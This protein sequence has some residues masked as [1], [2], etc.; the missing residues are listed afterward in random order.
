MFL[1]KRIEYLIRICYNRGMKPC[2]S[3]NKIKP[4]EEFYLQK[5]M[6]DSHLN[7]CKECCKLQ[8]KYRA[9]NNIHKAERGLKAEKECFICHQVK[10]LKDFYKHKGMFDG[11]LNKCK[12]CCNKY[13]DDKRQNN[14]Y[15]YMRGTYN[16]MSYRCRAVKRYKNLKLLSKDEWVV[17]TSHN[18]PKFLKLYKDWQRSGYKKA[19]A[20]SIDRINNSRGYEFDNMQWLT[21]SQNARKSSK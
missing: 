2:I 16:G 17:W 7:K 6:K 9:E 11:H 8:A 18:M 3:C 13:S 21:Q 19:F 14:P 10:P 4:L 15:Y 1:L 5:G 12:E 20:P